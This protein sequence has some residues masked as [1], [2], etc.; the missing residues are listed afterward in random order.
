[1]RV[2]FSGKRSLVTSFLVAMA[3]S[4]LI[5]CQEAPSTVT[6][7][8][9]DGQVTGPIADE[10]GHLHDDGESIYGILGGDGECIKATK[11]Q[12]AYVDY[13]NKLYSDFIKACINKTGA[14][15]WCQQLTRPNPDSADIFACTYGP[16]QA[17]RF[18]HPDKSTWGNAFEAVKIIEDLQRQGVGVRRIYNWWRPEPYNKNVEGAGGRHPLGTSI[19]VEF[20]SHRDKNL[21]FR[22]LCRMRRYGR[23][24]AIGYYPSQGLHLGVGDKIPNTWGK[25]CG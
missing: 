12:K 16:K 7:N 15:T 23:I 13:G 25:S 3:L 2:N 9:D 10:H 1:M 5:S 11:E 17:H 6:T 19:D 20:D 18:I 24:K 4:S 14:S 22:A 8:L 21:A